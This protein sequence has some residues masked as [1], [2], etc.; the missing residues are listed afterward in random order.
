MADLLDQLA[1]GR[2]VGADLAA[3]G[4]WRARAR[5]LAGEIRRVDSG[6]R[7]AEESVRLYPRRLL[8]PGVGISLQRTLE[9]MERAALTV[10]G[11]ARSVADSSRLEADYSPLRDTDIRT[12][13]AMVL[14]ELAEAPWRDRSECRCLAEGCS[15]PP[16]ESCRPP[17]VPGPGP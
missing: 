14:R 11:L 10:R 3:S 17:S 2:G 16:G 9:I 8:L 5:A 7:Q 12:G 1:R 6:L 15:Q 4:E 13:L